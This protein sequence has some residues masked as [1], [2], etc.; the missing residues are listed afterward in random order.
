MSARVTRFFFSL[1]II[2]QWRCTKEDNICRCINGNETLPKKKTGCSG[3]L[4]QPSLRTYLG[5]YRSFWYVANLFAL[6]SMAQMR[7]RVCFRTKTVMFLKLGTAACILVL[8][9]CKR[10]GT[11]GGDMN[12]M[13]KE[14]ESETYT[15]KSSA[16][17][18]QF[19]RVLLSTDR[20]SDCCFWI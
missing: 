17:N 11:T 7:Q 1:S 15:N 5:N 3:Q 6:L 8:L 13:K 16:F 10:G 2:L 4:T 14:R 12:K 19:A 9:R 18:Y 20:Q